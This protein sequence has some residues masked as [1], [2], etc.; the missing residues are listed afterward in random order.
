MSAI[1][2]FID[3]VKE[4]G[5]EH[6]VSDGTVWLDDYNTHLRGDGSGESITANFYDLSCENA[7]ELWSYRQK[8]KLKPFKGF[9]RDEIYRESMK[10]RDELIENLVSLVTDILQTFWFGAHASDGLTK[11]GCRYLFQKYQEELNDMN[12]VIDLITEAKEETENE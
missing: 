2:K 4:L 7:L 8:N 11:K 10:E 9:T 12:A 6:T 3:S 1:E 5:V